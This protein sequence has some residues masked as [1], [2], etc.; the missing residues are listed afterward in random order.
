MNALQKIV[1]EARITR[2]QARELRFLKEYKM[3]YT[4]R[5]CA[6]TYMKCARYVK[7]LSADK[8]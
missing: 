1:K 8:G 6:D 3:A 5:R 7:E 2:R 4:F